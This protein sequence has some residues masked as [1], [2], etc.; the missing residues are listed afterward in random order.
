MW[1]EGSSWIGDRTRVSCI[2][3]QLLYHWA[4]Q[5]AWRS[6]P[7]TIS[8]SSRRP[9]LL[10]H[11]L[12]KEPGTE[13]GL[14]AHEGSSWR[15]QHPDQPWTLR[16]APPLLLRPVV[17]DIW[18]HPELRE[19]CLHPSVW[20]SAR[21]FGPSG[22][23]LC[24]GSHFSVSESFGCM[25]HAIPWEWVVIRGSS[26]FILG[27]WPTR[28][29]SFQKGWGA[30]SAAFLSGL[31]WMLSVK[32]CVPGT[33]PFLASVMHYLGFLDSWIMSQFYLSFSWMNNP[34]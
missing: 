26:R 27:R 28:S 15:P 24:V 16:T 19:C 30:S 2:G 3:R 12:D 17:L 23:L 32:R 22:G 9:E 29:E 34:K 1:H 10:P 8:F 21:S 5:E 18:V 4:T 6:F 7:S 20:I 33:L 11:G 25:R 13:G 14:T 31:W